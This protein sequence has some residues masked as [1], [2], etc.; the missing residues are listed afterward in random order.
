MSPASWRFTIPTGFI[1]SLTLEASGLIVAE[2]SHGISGESRLGK[3]G[4]M[5]DVSLSGLQASLS[6]VMLA[7]D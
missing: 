2:L 7:P 6:H 3:S 5:D 1:P 4:S